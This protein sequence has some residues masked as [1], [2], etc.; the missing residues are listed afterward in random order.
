MF[1]IV[2][3]IDLVI[4][5]NLNGLGMLFYKIGFKNRYSDFAYNVQFDL[6]G[7]EILED[8]YKKIYLML[9]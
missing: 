6:S 8:S 7:T 5:F 2:R 9:N 3:L 4:S 1:L